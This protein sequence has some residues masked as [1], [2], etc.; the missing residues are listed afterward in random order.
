MN[1]L[2]QELFC[3]FNLYFLDVDECSVGLDDCHP[4]AH[5]TNTEDGFNCTCDIGYFGDGT[6]CE[7]KTQFKK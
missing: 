3:V 1:L 2:I 7:S 5:C 4:N 6:D